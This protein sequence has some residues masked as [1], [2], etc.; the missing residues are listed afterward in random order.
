MP[1]DEN[2]DRATSQLSFLYY[3]ASQREQAS[4]PSAR[5]WRS[6]VAGCLTGLPGR[7]EPCQRTSNRWGLALRAVRDTERSDSA[8]LQRHSLFR[9]FAQWPQ[10]RA[11]YQSTVNRPL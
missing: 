10:T 7:I 1:K 6:I 2:Y 4:R 11:R 5:L 8:G 9:L 3:I